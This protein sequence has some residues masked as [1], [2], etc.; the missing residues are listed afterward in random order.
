MDRKSHY[1]VGWIALP[2]GTLVEFGLARL[3]F[4]AIGINKRNLFELCVV[5]F[6]ICMASELRALAM[7]RSQVPTEMPTVIKKQAAA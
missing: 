6:L 3:A 5:A 7:V 2:C 4:L 1:Y